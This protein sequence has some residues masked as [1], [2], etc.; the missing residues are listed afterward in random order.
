M[1]CCVYSAKLLLIKCYFQQV[2]IECGGQQLSITVSPIRAIIIHQF[3]N[4]G[5]IINVHLYSVPVRSKTPQIQNCNYKIQY[6]STKRSRWVRTLYILY[7]VLYNYNSCG[8]V[9]FTITL[10][11]L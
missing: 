3:Q 2:E 1:Y 4:Q 10:R 9:W 7:I 6:K 11:N 8:T 5:T